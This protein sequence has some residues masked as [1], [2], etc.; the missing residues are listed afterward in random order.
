MQINEGDSSLENQ[1]NKLK[2]LD[3]IVAYQRVTNYL[4]AAQI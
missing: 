4:A 1:Q 3:N 2:Y